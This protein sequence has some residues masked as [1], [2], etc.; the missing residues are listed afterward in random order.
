[1]EFV[2]FS[3][4]RANST[5]QCEAAAKGL[6]SQVAVVSC[7]MVGL[8]HDVPFIVLFLASKDAGKYEN[9]YSCGTS[10]GDKY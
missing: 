7:G 1:M 3:V 4:D 10:M 2:C 9:R 8:N 6:C 5:Q